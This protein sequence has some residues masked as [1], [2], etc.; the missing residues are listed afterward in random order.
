MEIAV[1]W[2]FFIIFSFTFTSVCFVLFSYLFAHDITTQWLWILYP[3]SVK[4]RIGHLHE[5]VLARPEHTIIIIYIE[6]WY[7][8]FSLWSIVV[9]Y[10]FTKCKYLFSV[11]IVIHIIH[12]LYLLF[13]WDCITPSFFI[14]QTGYFIRQLY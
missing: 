9:S 5:I 14:G 1:L 4:L 3:K 10:S 6:K 11:K 12:Y 8:W 2:S 7:I 13:G